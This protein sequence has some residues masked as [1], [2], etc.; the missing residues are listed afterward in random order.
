ML[1]LANMPFSNYSKGAVSITNLFLSGNEVR[2]EIS[3]T[4]PNPEPP[5]FKGILVF[6]NPDRTS[7][8]P[9][10]T[11]NSYSSSYN[12]SI[13]SF[14]GTQPLRHIA[15]GSDSYIDYFYLFFENISGVNPPEDSLPGGLGGDEYS[16]SVGEAINGIVEASWSIDVFVPSAVT[17]LNV[18]WGSAFYGDADSGTFLSTA[19]V[20]EPSS[21]SLLL[22]AGAVLMAG[23]RRNRQKPISPKEPTP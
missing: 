20:P 23:R 9:G 18:F 15:I 12:S 22:A 21:L 19:T 4:F 17:Y 7:P 5:A 10:F 1:V 2:F 3:G 6:A 11:R 16:F 13:S 8:R 14:S